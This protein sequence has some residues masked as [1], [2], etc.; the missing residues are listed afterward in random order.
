MDCTHCQEIVSAALDG[1]ATTAEVDAAR[2][3]MRRCSLCAADAHAISALHDALRLVPAGEVPDLSARILAGATPERAP[4]PAAHSPGIVLR[5][6]IAA[7]AAV[8]V[9]FALP[10]VLGDAEGM[11]MHEARH[12]G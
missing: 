3:H 5:I 9:A 12:I 4:A 1:E 10:A 7:V 11:Q 8:L 2:N 6:A